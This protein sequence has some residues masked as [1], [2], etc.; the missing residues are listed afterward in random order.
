MV[1]FKFPQR[2][3]R[4]WAWWY[5]RGY[6]DSVGWR[7]DCGHAPGQRGLEHS[8]KLFLKEGSSYL[9]PGFMLM[10]FQ[11]S[12][13]VL[14]RDPPVEVKP[15]HYIY[16]PLLVTFLPAVTHNSRPAHRR[17]LATEGVQGSRNNTLPQKNGH[18]TLM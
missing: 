11:Y 6:Q 14:Q 5:P 17:P 2:A 13:R 18:V 7:Q 10:A 3:S 15:V 1:I 9:A 16:L 8:E 4:S 12:H